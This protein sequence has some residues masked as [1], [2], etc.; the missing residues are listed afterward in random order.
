MIASCGNLT[1]LARVEFP[2]LAITSPDRLAFTARVGHRVYW[3][4]TADRVK[5]RVGSL[6]VFRVAGSSLCFESQLAIAVYQR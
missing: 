4:S 5:L 1:L 2:K 6:G 3:E